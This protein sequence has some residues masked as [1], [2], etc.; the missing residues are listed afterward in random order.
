MHYR[1][2]ST[3]RGSCLHELGQHFNVFCSLYTV[4][5][6]F[7]G[8]SRYFKHVIV[9]NL[10]NMPRISPTKLS[11]NNQMLFCL[12]QCFKVVEGQV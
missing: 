1:P 3:H 9:Q 5:H 12:V 10:K 6:T 2:I 7:K 8:Y 11:Q 4:H